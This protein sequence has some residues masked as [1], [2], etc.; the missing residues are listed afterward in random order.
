MQ[1][2]I[3]M[4]GPPGAGKGTQASQLAG[5][6]NVP[7]I[8]TGDI[9][10]EAAQLETEFGRAVQATMDSGGLVGDEVMIS[11]VR[12]RLM[13]E[14]T[15]EGVVLDGF[16]RTVAQAEALDAILVDRVP[17]MVLDIAVPSDELLRRLA[18]RRVCRQCGEIFG[19][20]SGSE[21]VKCGG[22]VQQRSD[23]RESIV[24]ERL[25]VYAR[26]SEPLTNYYRGRLT[27]AEIDGSGTPDVV[28]RL[29]NAA[30]DRFQ[31]SV[32]RD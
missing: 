21:C 18:F 28:E 13:R 10:R 19:N 12:E 24:R 25:K 2:N 14:D 31:G 5:A 22:V 6:R 17:L 7:R 27:F 3:A 8:S 11:I 29:V 16:P 23:D 26:D 20:S 1:L 15:R 30:I 9:L 32:E 4:L